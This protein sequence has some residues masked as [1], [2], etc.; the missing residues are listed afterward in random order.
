VTSKGI[1]IAEDDEEIRH[2]LAIVFQLEN[3]SVFEAEDGTEALRIFTENLTTIH[4]VISDLGLP[5]LGGVEL[6]EHIRALSS[7]VK[8]IGASGYGKSNIR[9]EVLKA[10]G[11]E[12][13]PKPFNT[14]E[15]IDSVHRLLAL[16]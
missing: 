16:D 10:G 1:L 13:L 5:G 8:I 4:L 14:G 12:F 3:Y 11:D 9:E 6:I 2:L 15:L 7:S